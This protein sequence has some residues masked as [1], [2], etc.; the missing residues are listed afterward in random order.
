MIALIRICATPSLGGW[1]ASGERFTAALLAVLT[2][3]VSAILQKRDNN[4]S[5]KNEC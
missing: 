3:D 1:V 2:G 4:V 5:S